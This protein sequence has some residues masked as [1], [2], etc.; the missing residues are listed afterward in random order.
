MMI[1]IMTL[2]ISSQSGGPT[3]SNVGKNQ[4]YLPMKHTSCG[5]NCTTHRAAGRPSNM[6]VRYRMGMKCPK[7]KSVNYLAYQL[8]GRGVHVIRRGNTGVRKHGVTRNIR[9]F[10]TAE[11]GRICRKALGGNLA[12]K[13]S[14]RRTPKIKRTTAKK[15]VNIIGRC[16]GWKKTKVKRRAVKLSL[17]CSDRNH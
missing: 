14:H 2:V 11:M 4:V 13:S 17:I 16:T 15:Y 6:N 8:P 10:S 5:T 12:T 7:G 1:L 3:G 9:L